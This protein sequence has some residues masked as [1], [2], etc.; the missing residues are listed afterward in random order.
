MP[1]QKLVNGDAERLPLDVEECRFYRAERGAEHRARSPIGVAVHRLD[2]MLDLEWIFSDDEALEVFER[3]DDG[4]RLPLE[5]RLADAVDA[6][7]GEEFH[8]DKIR[9]R[10][11][12][13][14]DFLGDDFHGSRATLRLAA[15]SYQI[16]SS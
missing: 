8:E 5:R 11:I 13:D 4:F 10:R 14:E 7:V 6:F 12:R 2:Q 9:P 3:T 16:T 15:A 1:P